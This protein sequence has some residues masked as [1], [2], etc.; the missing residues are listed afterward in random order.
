[1]GAIKYYPRSTCSKTNSPKSSSYYYYLDP[2]DFAIVWTN[3]AIFT[4]GHL[5]YFYVFFQFL[6][7]PV[8][9][10]NMTFLSKIT[11]DQ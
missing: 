3:V 2:K 4:V 9:N 6:C 8:K 11:I 5:I 10:S 1:M 7:D